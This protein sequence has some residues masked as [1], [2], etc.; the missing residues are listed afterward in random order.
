MELFHLVS[1]SKSENRVVEYLTRH[2]FVVGVL[3]ALFVNI[4]RSRIQHD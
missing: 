3:Q 2:P 4:L 1:S